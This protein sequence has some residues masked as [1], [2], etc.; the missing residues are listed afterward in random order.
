MRRGVVNPGDIYAITA[1]IQR[2][3][4]AT[5]RILSLARIVFSN[6]HA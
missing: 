1:P 4:F 5:E 6:G 2:D 3:F